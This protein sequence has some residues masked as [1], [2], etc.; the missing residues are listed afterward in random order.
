MPDDVNFAIF[1]NSWD[2]T[3][4]GH[5]GKILELIDYSIEFALARI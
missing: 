5:L 1:V 4:E 2:G 3:K